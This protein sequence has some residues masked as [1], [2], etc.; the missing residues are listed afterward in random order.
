MCS[1]QIYPGHVLV[2]SQRYI[3]RS[4]RL[5]S[6][7][8]RLGQNRSGV[9]AGRPVYRTSLQDYQWL[10]GNKYQPLFSIFISI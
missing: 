8:R 1:K 10:P 6:L 4:E 9:L 2:D 5:C 3:R 7:Q